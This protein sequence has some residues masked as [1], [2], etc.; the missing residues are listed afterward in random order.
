[1]KPPLAWRRGMQVK[2]GILFPAEFVANKPALIR[3]QSGVADSLFKREIRF[4]PHSLRPVM[5]VMSNV[6]I[7]ISSAL[8]IA[9]GVC[10]LWAEQWRLRT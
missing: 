3:G 8:R 7:K 2:N 4:S 1:M 6:R 5:K 10:C 9:E